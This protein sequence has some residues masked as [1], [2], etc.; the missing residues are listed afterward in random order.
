MSANPPSG[1]AIVPLLFKDD[2]FRVFNWSATSGLLL[3]NGD[4]ISVYSS[5]TV[6][7]SNIF[8]PIV[9]STVNQLDVRCRGV[10]TSTVLTVKLEDS[11]GTAL[12]TKTINVSSTTYGMSFTPFTIGS[13]IS[14]IVLSSNSSGSTMVDFIALESSTANNIYPQ[15]TEFDLTINKKTV[16]QEIPFAADVVQQ[17]GIASRT[18]TI[19]VTKD[20]RST[21]DNLEVLITNN[22]PVMVSGPTLQMTGYISSV[23]G[24]I[25]AGVI[26]PAYDVTV[27]VVK[28]DMDVV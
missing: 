27:T 15:G 28:G 12:L 25:D 3:T 2:S 19:D 20:V 21:Y 22:T 24:E 5:Q 6:V 26:P 1:V 9:G 14:Q 16:S 8:P 23:Q 18:T 11:A 10:T 7:R 17:L 13:A 4:E